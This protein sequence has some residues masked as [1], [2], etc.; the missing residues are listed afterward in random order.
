M[1]VEDQGWSLPSD[2]REDVVS[3]VKPSDQEISSLLETVDRLKKLINDFVESEDAP[4]IEPTIAGSVAKGTIA[5][6]PDIDIFLLFPKA[7]LM[8]LNSSDSSCWG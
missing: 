2:I 8:T 6:E 1:V 3:K 7:A 5:G 4:M